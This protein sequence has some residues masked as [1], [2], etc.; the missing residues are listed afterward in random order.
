MNAVSFV[1]VL[2]MQVLAQMF[3]RVFARVFVRLVARIAT[4]A[5]VLLLPLQALAQ[6]VSEEGTGASAETGVARNWQTGFSEPASSVAR[7]AFG[8]HDNFLMPIVL[9]ICLF[10]F[11]LLGFICWRF[12]EKRN[13]TPS[14]RTHNSKLEVIW[15][16]VPV[17]ILAVLFVPSYNLMRNI[18]DVSEADLTVKATGHQWYWSYEYPDH[19]GLTFDSNLLRGDDL[20]D[21]SKRLLQTDNALVLPVGQKVRV[22]VTASDVLHSWSTP[23]FGVKI[24]AVPGRLNETWFTADKKGIYYGFCTELCGAGHAYMPVE[25]HIVSKAE[26]VIWLRK[27]KKRF[28]TNDDLQKNAERNAE[29]NP[30]DARQ[31]DLLAAQ[32]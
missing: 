18:E 1:P 12:S 32:K 6:S 28:A 29:G 19:D 14:R 5:V 22:I 30:G 3:A 13:P 9:V 8:F 27:A 25:V 10:V 2:R 17:A 26:F 24:D 15:T 21:K 4:P 20:K 7:Q 31:G 16:L 23:R 11:L